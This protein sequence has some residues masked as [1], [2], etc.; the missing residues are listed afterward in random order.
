MLYGICKLSNDQVCDPYTYMANTRMYVG[1][2]H[3]TG[4]C[5]YVKL[6]LQIFIT[7]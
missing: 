4:V 5:V 2:Y 1:R 6:V 3:E 7:M